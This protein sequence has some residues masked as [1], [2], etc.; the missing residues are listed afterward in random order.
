MTWNEATRLAKEHIAHTKMQI[1]GKTQLA[2][3]GEVEYVEDTEK[4]VPF[5]QHSV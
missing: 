2:H 3:Q 1:H 5:E 4:S